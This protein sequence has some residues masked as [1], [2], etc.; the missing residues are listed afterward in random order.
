[1]AR[2]TRR[3]TLGLI[4]AAAASA[5]F[6]VALAQGVESRKFLFILARGA[7]DGLSALV[8]DEES[9]V[10]ARPGLMANSARNLQIG[11][12]FSL[13]PAL[14]TLHG[15]YQ[16][17][18]AAF[19]HAA[20]SPYRGRS[21]FDGQDALE[22]LAAAGARDGWLNRA[23]GASGLT[24]LA[25][26]YDLP[27]ALRGDA[28]ATNWA[29]PV[30][31]AADED[32]IDRLA[33][34]YESDPLFSE[35]LELSQTMAMPDVQ[36]GGRGG[37]RPARAYVQSLQAVGQIL[38][39]TG[40]PG[41][42]MVSL[43]GW[44]SH[45]GQAN[46]LNTRFEGM[47]AGFAEL[48]SALG[49]YWDKTCIIM[50]SEFGRT[51]AENGTRGTDHGTGGL[52]ILAGGAVKGGQILGDWPG[53]APRALHE[54]RDLAPA[55][56]LTGLLKGLLRDHIGIDRHALDTQVFQNTARPMDGL[57]A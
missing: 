18:D 11:D 47:D 57:V 12:G 1:M 33:Q 40:G 16:S 21:H 5:S 7:M 2:I 19:I 34:L 6:P 38:G 8:P 41:I 13:H 54:G 55:N 49:P 22:T 9:L 56:D 51:V 32:L 46:F 23:L 53:T 25:I 31:E 52:V 4:G 17:G 36:M 14:S 39:Q 20:A 48:R 10:A 42:A 29:P 26:G 50:C 37:G 43:D 15:W 27:L 28:P 24:G 30:F 3:H 35:Q 44:D 45:A